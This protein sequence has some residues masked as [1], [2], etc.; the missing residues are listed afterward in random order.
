MRSG[1][2]GWVALRLC[3]VD[4]VPRWMFVQIVYH[5][6]FTSGQP[7]TSAGLELSYQFLI[8]VGLLSRRRRR[9]PC[10]IRR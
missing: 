3:R 2:A 10:A 5:G 4:A 7:R 1:R 8:S 9:S 6:S